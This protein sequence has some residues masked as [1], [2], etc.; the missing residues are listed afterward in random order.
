L[1]LYHVVLWV[2][3]SLLDPSS[4]ND[5]HDIGNRDTCFGHVGSGNNLAKRSGSRLKDLSLF[6]WLKG[7]MKR[8]RMDVAD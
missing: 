2:E 4:I 5:S 8:K 6:S 3:A 1:K 7:C